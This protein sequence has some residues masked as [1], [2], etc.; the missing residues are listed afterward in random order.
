MN[1]TTSILV[2]HDEPETLRVLEKTLNAAGRNVFV[3]SSGR[4]GLQ[5]AREKRPDLVLASARLPDLG[6][7]EVCKQIKGNSD[8]RDVF[9]ILMSDGDTN[10]VQSGA[11]KGCDAD[12]YLLAPL[13]PD[14][15]PALIQG[16]VRFRDIMAS[17]LNNGQH[18]GRK[19]GNPPD[20]IGLIHPEGRL[21]AVNSQAVAIFGYDSAWE[22]LGKSA[23][24]LAPAGE[25]ERIKAGIA[26]TLK[27]GFFA[28]PCSRCDGEMAFLSRLN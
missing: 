22:M 10:A 7:M 19:N 3:A 27:A 14:D 6:E 15:L 23:F 13:N 18:H 4:S 12:V 1:K 26:S 24:D 25:Q 11:G 16:A 20:A 5:L 8:P 2:L 21:L 28:T 9:F 17:P